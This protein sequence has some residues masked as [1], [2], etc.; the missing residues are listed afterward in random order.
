MRPSTLL[1]APKRGSYDR[2]LS[3]AERDAEHRE[4][5]LLA[6]AEVLAEG[7]ITV[8]RIVSRAGVGRSTFYEFFDDPEH[9]LLQLE[10]R[11]LRGLAAAMETALSE[12]RTPL[13]RVRGISRHWFNE[14]ETRTMEARVA[15]S[16][17]ADLGSLSPAGELLRHTLQ[18]FGE[19]A[20]AQ[21]GWTKAT[22][23][24]SLLATAAAAE[25][26]SRRHLTAGRLREAPLQL[27]D[28]I[29]RLLR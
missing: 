2:S 25:A 22:D 12:S 20:H 11:S 24:V 3:R 17:R 14:L 9:L 28:V 8:A 26:I 27:V 1:P 29:V 7:P 6:A 10:Q 5:L 15:L 23:S 16:T 21:V 19:S 18:R 4:R 13:E